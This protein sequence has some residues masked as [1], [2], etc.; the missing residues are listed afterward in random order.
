MSDRSHIAW[1]IFRSVGIIV[2]STDGCSE[3]GDSVGLVEVGDPDG[4]P[5]IGVD[6]G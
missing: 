4:N 5:V 1:Y 6:V 3:T 2:G